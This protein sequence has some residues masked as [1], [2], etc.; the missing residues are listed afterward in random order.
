[1]LQKTLTGAALSLYVNGIPFGVATGISWRTNAGRKPLYGIDSVL[2]F[3][4]APGAQG[5]TVEIECYRLRGDGGLEGRGLAVP[6]SKIF[7]EKYIDILVIDRL[8]GLAIFRIDQAAVNSQSW[9]VNEKGVM[10][11]NFELEGIEWENESFQSH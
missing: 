9:R 1:M 7:K 8:T 11:G 2:P 4:L 3:E 10:Q 6:D 5:V